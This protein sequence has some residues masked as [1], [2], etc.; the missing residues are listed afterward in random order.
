MSRPGIMALL[1]ALIAILSV[2]CGSP[3]NACEWEGQLFEN[4]DISNIFYKCIDGS[5]VEF[6]CPEGLNFNANTKQCDWPELA[7]SK[8]E[9]LPVFVTRKYT[10]YTFD[11]S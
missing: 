4:K 6:A 9:E 7:I 10:S 5:L 8:Q 3:L 1:V 11:I 2:V